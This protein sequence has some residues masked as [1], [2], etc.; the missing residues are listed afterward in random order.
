MPLAGEME[1]EYLIKKEL[2]TYLWNS[3]TS[4]KVIAKITPINLQQ[5]LNNYMV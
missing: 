1:A 4:Q 3:E 5:I 2:P